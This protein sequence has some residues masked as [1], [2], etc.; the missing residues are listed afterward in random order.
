MP[1]NTQLNPGVGGDV[2]ASD[3][4]AGI[5]FQRVKVVWGGEDIASDTEVSNPLPVSLTYAVVTV[6]VS[7]T[8][9]I[10]ASQSNTWA[11]TVNNPSTN[12]VLASLTYVPTVAASQQGVWTVSA[13]LTNIS[14]AVNN[15]TTN[16]IP[17]SETYAVRS[18]AITGTPTVLASQTNTWAVTVNNPST[19]PVLASLTYVPT[20]AASQQGI[21]IVQASLTNT[22]A[23]TV[24]N[25]STNPVLSSLTYGLQSVAVGNTVAASL[26]N[27]SVAVNNPATN[28][29][30]VSLTYAVQSVAISGT[31]SVNAI[32]SGSWQVGQTGVGRVNIATQA[33]VSTQ[34]IGPVTLGNQANKINRFITASLTVATTVQVQIASYTVSSGKTFYWQGFDVSGFLTATSSSINRISAVSFESPSGTKIWTGNMFNPSSGE[35]TSYSHD[36]AEPIPVTAGSVLRTVAVGAIGTTVVLYQVNYWGYEV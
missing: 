8:P 31:P 18:V 3:E 2:L 28:P 23:V 9:T 5:K 34:P 10:L 20:V 4:I 30:P 7:G 26:T 24:N 27:I 25:P 11:I 33:G 22:W 14:V 32:Q 17:V 6:A 13:S 36:Y 12:P 29:V 19:N 16:P 21:W 15:P 35:G 1:D